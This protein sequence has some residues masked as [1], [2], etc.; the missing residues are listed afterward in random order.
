MTIPLQTRC[1]ID[2][3]V[4][5]FEVGGKRLAFLVFRAICDARQATRA[6]SIML[7]HYIRLRLHDNGLMHRGGAIK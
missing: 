7:G 2:E 1:D 5:A 4:S 6:E 3:V